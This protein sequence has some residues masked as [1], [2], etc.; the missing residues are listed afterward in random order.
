MRVRSVFVVLIAIGI[1]LCSGGFRSAAAE[2]KTVEI[3]VTEKG[4]EPSEI[5][6]KKGEPLTLVVTRKTDKTCAR[7]IVIKDEK[8]NAELPLNKAVKLT[9]TPAKSGEIRYACGMDMF[10][11]VLKVE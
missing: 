8:I 11:G 10:S 5:A 6:V 1:A 2:G 9:F 4:F 7:E 3:S